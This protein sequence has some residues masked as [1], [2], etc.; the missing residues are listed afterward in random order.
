MYNWIGIIVLH[1]IGITIVNCFAK[2]ELI[3]HI[4]LHVRTLN[5]TLTLKK[6]IKLFSTNV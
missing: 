2:N 4:L 6:Y 1:C 3:T 5:V